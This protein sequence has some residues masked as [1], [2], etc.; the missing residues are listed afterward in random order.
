M[1][2]LMVGVAFPSVAAKADEAVPE[3]A[4]KGFWERDTLTG[5]WGGLRTS[6]EESGLKIGGVY[7]GEALGNPSGG[8]RRRA[9][10]EGL[11]EI[12]IDA[13][14]DKLIGWQ[15]LTFHTSLLQIHGR[16]LSANFL[17][18]QFAVRDIEAAPA[19]RIWAMWLQ[20][21]FYDD[22][23]SLRVGQI[24]EQE[25]FCI[26]ANGA[27]FINGTFGWPVG[28][29]A[30]MPS[31]G[32]AYPLAV[33]GA[34]IKVQPTPELAAL[35]AVFN[36]DAAPTN[37]GSSADPQ[38][39]N[40]YGTNFDTNQSPHWIGEVQYGV[41]QGKD[42]EGLPAMF[43]VGGWYHTG[44]FLDLRYDSTGK[45]LGSPTSNGLARTYRGSWGVYGI[46]DQMLW[47]QP[48]TEDGGISAFSRL[49]TSPE[50]RS[51]M[52]YYGE[53]GLTWKG[54][55][56]G[57]DSDVAGVAI[58]YGRMSPALASRD[59]DAI[60][61]GGSN[62]S[63]RDFEM[64]SEVLYRAQI[65]PWLTLVPNVQYVMHPGGGVGLPDQPTTRIPD[66]TI[67]GLRAV[68]KL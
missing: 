27:Y 21:S 42:A 64:V 51:T 33:T 15:G 45:S 10:A 23:A 43:K 26:S 19:G 30:N 67:V 41:N 25:E 17:S 4:S 5:D 38:R 31:G 65:N 44:R 3:P 8:L 52:P 48:G 46:V 12:D 37:M 68:L 1:I 29:S 20:Q 47:K 13:D 53:I 57:R 66:A 54:M 62:T 40:R 59:R 28:F 35:A 39:R 14:F 18:N 61:L 2:A 6:L 36:G 56:E 32:G 60:A 63:V 49:M 22:L 7:T 9:V 50:D 58:G 34:R 55:I 16:S 11:L 24:P